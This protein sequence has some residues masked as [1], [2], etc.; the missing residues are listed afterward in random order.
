MFADI[1]INFTLYFLHIFLSLS[2]AYKITLC[3]TWY[4]SQKI[5]KEPR[6]Q[7]FR[8]LSLKNQMSNQNSMTCMHI[9]ST[10]LK[11]RGFTLLIS[12]PQFF[13][14]QPP[15]NSQITGST[16]L[17]ILVA[18]NSHYFITCK[19]LNT[20]ITVTTVKEGIILIRVCLQ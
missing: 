11:Y 20:I 18:F 17:Q 16:W 19:K 4:T 3:L 13:Y 7:K 14:P 15:K 10:S 8:L 12:P 6:F 9:Q 5:F 2:F 1:S